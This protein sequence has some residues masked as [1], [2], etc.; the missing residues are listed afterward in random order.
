MKK[1]VS[2]VLCAMMLCALLS[3][4]AFVSAPEVNNTTQ[5]S[6]VSVKAVDVSSTMGGLRNYASLPE[7]TRVYQKGE[8]I[9]L[10]VTIE[11]KNIAKNQYKYLGSIANS[12]IQIV[13][14]SSTVDLSYSRYSN[15]VIVS[16]VYS[17]FYDSNIASMVIPGYTSDHYTSVD[18]SK[19]CAYDAAANT[20]TFTVQGIEKNSTSFFEYENIAPKIVDGKIQIAALKAKDGTETVTIGGTSHTVNFTAPSS[21]QYSIIVAGVTKEAATGDMYAKALVAGAERFNTTN[22][23]GTLNLK[24]KY[25]ITRQIVPASAAADE[26]DTNDAKDKLWV[27][28]GGKYVAQVNP[29]APDGKANVNWAGGLTTVGGELLTTKQ[30]TNSAG[31]VLGENGIA[32]YTIADSAG[33]IVA[34]LVTEYTYYDGD[35]A[36]SIALFAPD[37][38]AGYAR[39]L[40]NSGSTFYYNDTNEK[41]ENSADIAAMMNFFGFSTNFNATYKVT[42]D[43]FERLGAAAIY[44]ESVRGS[45][46]TG[47]IIVDIPTVDE[48]TT[49]IEQIPDEVIPPDEIEIPATGH[50]PIA[51]A[52]VA[53]AMA[54]MAAVLLIVRKQNSRR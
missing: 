11:V 34:S 1:M 42:D 2:I 40:Y 4:F 30:Y 39:R 31:K 44:S 23:V 29:K 7:S 6:I 41:V 20:V 51:A 5:L 12:D 21:I 3:G 33:K 37:N 16:N 10:A 43:I 38:G 47:S 15:P 27:K 22:G 54:C 18:L 17:G 48:G 49:D 8:T 9:F 19:V 50:A 45:Y 28:V 36:K 35:A 25:T 26:N 46:K 13:L 32:V 24:N 53:A 14:G 52:L